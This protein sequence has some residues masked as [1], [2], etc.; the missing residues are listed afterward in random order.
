MKFKLIF[1]LFNGIVLLSFI[2][3]FMIPVLLLGWEHSR[4]FWGTNWPL[5]ALFLA[6]MGGLNTYFALNWKLFSFLEAENWRGLISYLEDRIYSH[7]KY[8]KQ[9]LHVLINSYILVSEPSR[10]LE[11][12]QKCRQDRP[13][14]VPAFALQFGIPHLL[15]NDP[16]DLESYYGTMRQQPRCND[17]PWIEWSFAFALLLQQRQHE[18]RDVLLALPRQSKNPILRALTYY[19]LDAFPDQDL[20]VKNSVIEGKKALRGRYSISQWHKEVEKNRNNLQ[21]VVLANLVKDVSAWI[22]DQSAAQAT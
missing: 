8:R 16:Q 2:F 11:L 12:E 21:V 7:G 9:Y 19:L 18:A 10:I 1:L 4:L 17:R 6:I 14:L 5:A 15:Q 22:F 20:E 13:D 3:V